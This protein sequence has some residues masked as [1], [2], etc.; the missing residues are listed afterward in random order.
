MTYS[1]TQSKGVYD[2]LLDSQVNSNIL[3]VDDSESTNFFN[4]MIIERTLV[5]AQVTIAKNGQEAFD[6]LLK[7]VEQECLPD[8]IFLDINMPVMDGWEFLEKYKRMT[9]LSKV[10]TIILMLGAELKDDDR[11]RVKEFGA[12]K[13]FSEKML[14]KEVILRLVEKYL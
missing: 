11:E 8:L 7:A 14:K 12:I 2:V 5:D 13:E 9:G 4:K 1:T 10:A 3:L 6:M